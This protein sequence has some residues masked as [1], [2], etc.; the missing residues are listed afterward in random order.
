MGTGANG[1]RSINL[2]LGQTGTWK[3]EYLGKWILEENIYLRE[4][5]TWEMG[6]GANGLH[7]KWTFGERGT[8]S[9]LIFLCPFP[10]KCLQMGTRDKWTFGRKGYPKCPKGV[11]QVPWAHYPKMFT[12]GRWGKWRLGGN[13]YPSA[14]KGYIPSALIFWCPFPPNVCK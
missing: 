1:H 12:N 6:T 4:L 10:L 5:G 11:S 8:L 3:N 7:G 2:D 9:S 14:L 13:G